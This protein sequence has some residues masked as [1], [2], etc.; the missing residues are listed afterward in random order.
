[1]ARLPS[2]RPGRATADARRAAGQLR[3]ASAGPGP[4]GGKHARR[5]RRCRP[6]T[7]LAAG[8][9]RGLDRAADVAH[10]ATPGAL[11]DPRAG[12]G[13]G[14]ES[15]S[16]GAVAPPIDRGLPHHR[17][18]STSRGPSRA[19]KPWQPSAR[20]RSPRARAALHAGRGRGLDRAADTAYRATGVRDGR[21]AVGGIWAGFGQLR[22]PGPRCRL[23]TS[24]CRTT[25]AA[26]LG[27]GR[28]RAAAPRG[29]S[30]GAR[31][32]HG[33]GARRGGRKGRSAPPR[34]VWAGGGEP[35]DGAL[36]PAAE[37]GPPHHLGSSSSPA[38]EPDRGAGEVE[39]AGSIAGRT[40]GTR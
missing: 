31:S 15:R 2:G 24:A 37:R 28:H 9:G 19:A 27:R 17:G 4:D 18:R 38:S 21:R 30:A 16:T 25:R 20:V 12:C 40:R 22:D 6:S 8:R 34:R 14:S 10:H 7:G 33:R 36:A 11:G 23:S 3:E 26:P 35:D 32:S 5:V 29:R 1:M 13:C 39:R